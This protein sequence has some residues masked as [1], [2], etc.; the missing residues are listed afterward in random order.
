MRFHSWP[1]RS[2]LVRTLGI[3]LLITLL[4]LLP[5]P[6]DP[7][8]TAE[9]RHLS[10]PEAMPGQQAPARHLRVEQVTTREQRSAIAATGAAIV[11]VGPDY[12]AI[13]ATAEEERLVRALGY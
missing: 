2:P 3:L 12:V 5:R 13:V 9:R 10:P 11:E 7:L 4:P 8:V 6:T 1:A